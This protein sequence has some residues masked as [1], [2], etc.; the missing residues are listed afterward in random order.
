M[1]GILIGA[2]IGGL[3]LLAGCSDAEI[4]SSRDVAHDA[5]YFDYAVDGEEGGNI[6]CKLQYKFAGKNGTSLVLDSPSRV[7]LDGKML[8]ADSAKYSGAF[9]EITMPASEF[10]GDHSIAFTGVNG[11][12]Y[13]EKFQFMPISLK[14][15][16]DSVLERKEFTLELSNVK[17]GSV[18]FRLVLT[19]TSFNQNWFNDMVMARNGKIL[20]TQAMI[21]RLRPGPVGLE[22]YWEEERPLQQPSKEGGRFT[23]N[24]ALKR[25][26]MLR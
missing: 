11:K 2:W 8:Q 3:A 16:L 14:A 23:I 21:N 4:G 9:Y 6:T 13:E 26:A 7:L 10:A 1:K 5:I 19:D 17:Q 18:P 20:I 24:Y 25:E 22:L 12:L 15:P